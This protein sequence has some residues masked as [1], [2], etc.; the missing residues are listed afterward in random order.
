MPTIS[1]IVPV[2]KVEQYIRRCIDSIIAQT[3]NDWE[4]LLVDDGSPDNSGR[5]C[6]EYAAEDHRIKTIHKKNGGVSAARFTG[7]EASQ[8][9]WLNFVDSDDYIAPYALEVLIAQAKDGIDL[10]EARM[11]A[12]A[13]IERNNNPSI[14]FAN[15]KDYIMQVVST[16]SKWLG[17]PVCK[18]FRRDLFI[19][20]DA[21]NNPKWITNYE[22]TLMC[23]RYSQQI[24]KA[25]FVDTEIYYYEYN[26]N[27]ASKSNTLTAKYH[28]D[29]LKI[30]ES[31][32]D[33][34]LDNP[35][36]FEIWFNLARNFFIRMFLNCN[37]WNNKD[38]YMQ[39]LL[40]TLKNEKKKGRSYTIGTNMCISAASLPEFIHPILRPVLKKLLQAKL[41]HFN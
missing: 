13:P 25:A 34:G 35:E 23:F 41:K 24:R 7:V 15:S 16:N 14:S 39:K 30:W 40:D 8:G 9:E 19:K 36:S 4:L 32:L 5:I 6:D 29:F 12:K 10:I 2:Y 11:T 37:D 27:S 18:L 20:S 33:G 26:T 22:D 17:T 31:H 38:G 3:Y 21:L 1:I 28:A